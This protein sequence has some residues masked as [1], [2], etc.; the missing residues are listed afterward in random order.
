MTSTSAPERRAA[1][2]APPRDA[3]PLAQSTTTRQPV[4]AAALERRATHRVGPS[5]DRVDAVDDRADRVARS[6]APASRSCGEQRVAARPRAR[7]STS[8][9]ELAPAGGEQLDAVVGEGVVRRRDHRRRRRRRSADQPGHRRGGHHAERRRRRRPRRP[10]RRPARPRAAGPDRRVSRPTTNRS[11][12]RAPGP[13]RGPSAS[14]QLGGELDVGDA[15][16]PVGPELAAR[17]T[18]PAAARLSAWSTAE[19][20]GPS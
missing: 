5:A 3:A 9:V 13:R 6:A 20:C 19:P 10:G 14:D 7:A 12:R 4:E 16:D 17:V 8:S 1:P 11:P 15:P 2:R 18:A